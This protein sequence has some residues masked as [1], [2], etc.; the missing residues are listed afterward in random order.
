[1]LAYRHIERHAQDYE[2]LITNGGILR[3]KVSEVGRVQRL[4]FSR[5]WARVV[6]EYYGSRLALRSHGREVVC[7]R[8]LTGGQRLAVPPR[9]LREQLR[10]R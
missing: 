1:V 8:H 3:I 6:C 10:S 5:W 4:K 7:G 2:R 9:A